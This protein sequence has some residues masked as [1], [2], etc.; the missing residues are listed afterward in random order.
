MFHHNKLDIQQ[1]EKE[2]IDILDLKGRLVL[3]AGD[4]ALRD[5]V[6]SLFDNGNRQLIH[7]LQEIS[8]I[9]TSGMQVL[10]FLS[11]EY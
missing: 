10:L 7:N 2:G 4:I 6:Q 3:G 11:E 9:D 1:R 8:E 5:F